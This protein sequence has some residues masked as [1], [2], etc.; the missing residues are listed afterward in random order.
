MPSSLVLGGGNLGAGPE[1]AGRVRETPGVGA[2]TSLRMGASQ[3][4]GASLQVL[5]IV[6]ATFPAVSGLE[7][8]EGEAPQA[9]AALG[10][11]RAII[12]N[13][14]SALQSGTKVGD[15]VPLR[16]PEGDLPYR[17]VAIGLDYLNA[18][19]ATGHVSQANLARDFHQL[20]D[21]LLMA[22]A[23]RGADV[24]AVRTSLERVVEDYPAFSLLDSAA[25]RESQEQALGRSMT[26]YYVLLLAIA[27]PGLIAMINTLAINP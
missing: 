8:S 11:E 10:S 18:K 1:L 21:V 4:K 14:V 6:P 15:T 23:A 27:L 12:L 3:A 26:F 24:A 17:V 16:T 22:N 25:F 13:G 9:Y 7:F 2:V 20:S 19:L 5:G